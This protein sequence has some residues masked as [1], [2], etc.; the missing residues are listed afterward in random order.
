MKCDG[1]PEEQ[2]SSQW[3]KA[4]A[5]SWTWRHA[6]PALLH[7]TCLKFHK[8][9]TLHFSYCSFLLSFEIVE[10]IKGFFL[11]LLW[12]NFVE[13]KLPPLTVPGKD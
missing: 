12:L 6:L 11:T 7:D 3:T 9:R 4:F 5:I 2:E 13:F 10:Q 1:G 8:Q